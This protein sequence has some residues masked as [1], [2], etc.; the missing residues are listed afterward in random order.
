MS[1]ILKLKPTKWDLKDLIQNNKSK[2]L[3]KHLE[4]ID[5][6]VKQFEDKKTTL[7]PEITVKEFLQLLTHS[8]SISEDL[9]KVSGYAHLKYAEDTSSNDAGAVVTRMNI[10]A[11][12]VSNRLLFFDLWFKKELDEENANRL[13]EGVPEVYREY[14]KHER[15]LSKFTLK[16][17]EE[18]IINILDVTGISALIKI[19]DRMTNGFEYEY[20]EQKGNKK[21]R[22]IFTNKEKL[23][24]M[25]RSSKPSERI[26]AYKSLWATY[27]KNSGVLGEIYISRVLNWRNEYILLRKFPSPI[28]VRNLHNDI[29]DKTVE[30]LLNVCRSNASIFQKYFKEKAKMLK[31][32]KLERYHLYA[33]LKSQNQKKIDYGTALKMVLDAYEDFDPQFRSSVKKLIEKKHIDSQ[34]RNNKQGGA[35]C[36]TIT[37]QI[38]PFVLLNYDGTTRD[39][40]TMAHEFG[41]AVH[42]MLASDKPIS[43]QHP[44]LPLAETASVFGEMLLNDKLFYKVSKK[45]NKILLAEQIDDFYA[46]I[47]RQAFFTM[48][49]I[50]AHDNISKNNAMTIDELADLYLGNLKEQFSD[51]LKI[52]D[53]FKYEWLYIPHI[54]HTPFYCYAYSFGNLLV[55][56]L[57]QQYKEEGKNFIPKYLRILSA[58]GTKKPENLLMEEGIDITS[59]TF[60]QKGFDL[61]SEKINS[62]KELE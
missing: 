56:S 5:Q 28:S 49:E 1:N 12:E 8:E 37:P 55:M 41:H 16:E 9:S 17:S 34:I 54:Y 53:D 31:I 20:I 59:E 60:W 3:E 26:A 45:E 39:I 50:S 24:S 43:V 58:G 44:P 15:A 52:S 10:F 57:Y 33:P 13:I 6:K 32:K 11:T 61:V 35:F 4:S 42:S 7:T 18:K 19:Y 27:K 23:V 51:S 48:F 36:S 14:L 40:S 29:D 22:K 47:M 38:D 62:L 30:T 2:E 25:V 21:I 46:T